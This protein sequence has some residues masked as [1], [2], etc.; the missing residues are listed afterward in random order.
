M[1]YESI[2]QSAIIV[3][4]KRH[5][6]YFSHYYYN[7]S[8]SSQIKSKNAKTIE[9]GKTAAG[10]LSRRFACVCLCVFTT[11]IIY[12]LSNLIW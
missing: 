2:K 1:A 9:K 12:I 11:I 3:Y 10:L 6:Y 7:T 8:M 5:I 4:P